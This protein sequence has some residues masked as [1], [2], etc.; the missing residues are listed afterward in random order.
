[1]ASVSLQEKQWQARF[2]AAESAWQLRLKLMQGASKGK[3]RQGHS[4]SVHREAGQAASRPGPTSNC[5]KAAPSLHSGQDCK[6]PLQPLSARMT[7]SR[8][9]TAS[10][11]LFPYF[12]MANCSLQCYIGVIKYCNH[13]FT[14]RHCIVIGTL[15]A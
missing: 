5:S 15:C 12:C 6:L 7:I 8:P 10:G 13:T 14:L 11:D 1:M 2:K 9:Q 3:P 4:G